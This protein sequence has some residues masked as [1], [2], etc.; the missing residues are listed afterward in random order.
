MQTLP[1]Q[2][3]CCVGVDIGKFEHVAAITDGLGNL[4]VAPFR[5]GPYQADFDRFF[6][7]LDQVAGGLGGTP[8]IAME[9]TGHYY[10]PLATAS[11]QRY[12]PA[13]VYLVQAVD[14]AHRRQDWNR[15]T[16]KNDEVDACIICQVLREGHG[17]PYQPPSGVY[18]RL[19]H[20]ER[21]R[22]ARE[23]ASTRLKNQLQGHVDRLFP[24]LVIGEPQVAKRLHPLWRDLWQIAT[25]RRLLELCPDPYR[26]RQHS[27]DSLMTLFQQAGYWMNRPYAAKLLAAVRALY[28]PDPAVVAVRLPLLAQD[29]TLLTQ[30]EQRIARVET[31]MAALL[32]ATWGRWLRPTG[33]APAL[34]AS[35]VA[36][37]GDLQAYASPR[38]LFGRS[39]LHSGCADS[40]LRQ[41]HGQGQR[42]VR[43][44]DRHLRRQLLR[45]TYSMLRRYPALQR[46]QAQLQQ[47]G[48]GPVAAYIAVARKLCG[49]LFHLATRQEPFDP[50]QL[51]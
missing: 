23:Q 51:A 32:D 39:G 21:Y 34:L 40:G 33:V 48:L 6:A 11:A 49:I 20:L 37:I 3:W 14:V 27:P 25:P 42:I 19:Y 50:A 47:R 31:E 17:R 46:Y 29:L 30:E 7:L 45:F 12:G 36:T 44:G 5:F 38:Q 16:F 43:P 1:P 2:R 8:L 41:R 10:E 15:G 26:L 4:L 9:P 13:Q 18:L 24:G 35:L 28:L 22:L